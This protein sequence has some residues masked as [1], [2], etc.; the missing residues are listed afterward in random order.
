MIACG[1]GIREHSWGFFCSVPFVMQYKIVMV[2]KTLLL[3]TPGLW[4]IQLLHQIPH[5]L[6]MLVCVFLCVCFLSGGGAHFR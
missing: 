5:I 2:K 1:P 4:I 3:L 6:E